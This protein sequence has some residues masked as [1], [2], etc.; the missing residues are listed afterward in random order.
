MLDLNESFELP[1]SERVTDEIENAAE[2]LAEGGLADTDDM[3]LTYMQAAHEMNRTSAWLSQQVKAQS[4]PSEVHGKRRFFRH[5]VCVHV[6]ELIEQHGRDWRQHATWDPPAETADVETDEEA[7]PQ[8]EVD[9]VALIETIR[10]R[11]EECRQQKKYEASSELFA[12][13]LDFMGA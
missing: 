8:S 9:G 1:R 10:N 4:I 3:L 12:V 11:A 7:D 13:L 6:R 2:I 5:S